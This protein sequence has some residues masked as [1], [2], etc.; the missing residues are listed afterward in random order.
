MSPPFTRLVLATANP[1]KKR[2]LETLLAGSGIRVESLA[3]YPG[4]SLPLEDGNSFTEN[5]RLKAAAVAAAAGSWALSDDS[6]LQ[7]DFL[8]GAPGI[9]SA[10]FAGPQADDAAN[11]RRLLAEL[12]GVSEAQRSAAFACV[13]ALISPAG[14]EFFFSGRCPGRISF[15]LLGDGG[16]GYDPLFLLPPDYQRSMAQLSPAEK[17]RISHRG[18]ALRLFLAWL[19]DAGAA[20]F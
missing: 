1:G 17:N 8:D 6:G 3:D 5:A 14:K 12:E 7:V 2:E 9:H 11:N 4:L 15:K 19:E 10:R 16:F 13:L 20:G 18:R